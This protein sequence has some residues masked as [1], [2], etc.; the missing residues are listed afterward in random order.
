MF[1]Q[2]EW[3]WFHLPAFVG[4]LAHVYFSFIETLGWGFERVKRIA[5]TWLEGLNDKTAIERVTWAKRLAFNIGAYNLM[6]AIGLG[7]TLAADPSIG[8]QLAIFFGIW[9]LGA[10]LAAHHTRVTIA[11]YVQGGLGVLLLAAA[12]A[13]R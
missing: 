10:A 8:R 11:F 4:F 13:L 7:W 6:L 1:A 3:H 12:I 5:P 9:L 2:M